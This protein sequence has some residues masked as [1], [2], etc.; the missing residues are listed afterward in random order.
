MFGYLRRTLRKGEH[1][2][3]FGL[4]ASC[5][6]GTSIQLPNQ[7]LSGS[8]CI[9]AARGPAVRRPVTDFRVRPRSDIRPHLCS[10]TQTSAPTSKRPFDWRR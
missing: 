10:V 9:G 8:V 5:C 2:F 3:S 4:S 6:C 1:R 7:V